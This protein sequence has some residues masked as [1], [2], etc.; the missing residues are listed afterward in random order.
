MEIPDSLLESRRYL[1]QPQESVD[2][3][4]EKWGVLFINT[5][6]PEEIEDINQY[7]YSLYS[8]SYLTSWSLPA[9]FQ[10]QLARLQAARRAPSLTRRYRAI[11]GGSPLLR[12]TRL[13]AAGVKK[14]LSKQFPQAEVFAG[15]RYAEPYINEE[16]DAAVDEG[17]RH[18]ILFPLS[19]QGMAITTY[20]SLQ[21]VANWLEDDDSKLT[22][23]L[24]SSW[25]K[26]AEFINLL[27]SRIEDARENLVAE[28]PRIIFVAR[29]FPDMARGKSGRYYKQVAE[30]ADLAGE[31]FD[32]ILA[33]NQ[34]PGLKR[35]AEPS[36]EKTVIA[37]A[38]DS[39]SEII[40][41]PISLTTD[42]LETLFNIDITL[43]ETATAVGIK[44]FIRTE[45]LNDD[46]LFTQ[47][48]A[49]LIEEKI[50]A[51]EPPE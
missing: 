31:G 19:P 35:I 8:D 21:Q 7:L 6:G 3:G 42:S 1:A 15:M 22:V 43:R 9:I 41:A 18:V 47:F 34:L 16:L 50:G 13:T 29:A 10:K 46:P 25:Y 37:L 28:N 33:Y 20:G 44:N 4:E 12:W 11:G 23:S 40:I 26:R 30:T 14:E 32:W 48:L 49:D 38:A 17:C 51:K 5:G 45:A 39:V 2:F 36:L 24:I 27:R